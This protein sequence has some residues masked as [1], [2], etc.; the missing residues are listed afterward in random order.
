MRSTLSE[1]EFAVGPKDCNGSHAI[2]HGLFRGNYNEQFERD[3]SIFMWPYIHAQCFMLR[4]RALE[5][6]PKN[7]QTSPEH[8]FHTCAIFSSIQVQ[9]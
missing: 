9:Y 7:F 6:W 5:N 8:Q 1:I 3:L 2:A 4:F